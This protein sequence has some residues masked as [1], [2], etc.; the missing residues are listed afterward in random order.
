MNRH[1]NKGTRGFTENCG[2]IRDGCGKDEGSSDQA[3]VAGTEQA[4]VVL[5]RTCQAIHPRPCEA[6]Q[7]SAPEL[8]LLR[9]S[10]DKCESGEKPTMASRQP[11]YVMRG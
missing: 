6:T 3:F 10:A 7:W 1:G 9:E 2:D 8:V 4:V 11:R 5:G